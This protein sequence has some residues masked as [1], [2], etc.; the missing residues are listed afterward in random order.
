MY[1]HR[2]LQENKLATPMMIYDLEQRTDDLEIFHTFPVTCLNSE[3]PTPKKSIHHKYISA[4]L[5][6]DFKKAVGRM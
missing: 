5:I 6:S 1:I 4:H 2:L 3:L